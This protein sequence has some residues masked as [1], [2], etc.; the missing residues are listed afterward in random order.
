M[1]RASRVLEITPQLH[2]RFWSKVRR[3]DG[4]W[5][6]QSGR[7]AAGYG[8]IQ[9]KLVSGRFVSEFAHRV[10]WALTHGALPDKNVCHTCDTPAC[11]RP[12]HLWLGTDAENIADR[13]AKGRTARG[14]AVVPATRP[15][16]EGHYEARV[17][18]DD[19]R[20]IRRRVESGEQLQTLADAYGMTKQG[21]WRIVHRRSWKHVE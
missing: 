13:D 20:E 3:G 6:W 8:L 7:N 9:V 5:L 11:V 2:E 15:R 4:C 10:A 14:D 16:G 19:V 12:T 17:T 21:I 18:E 1:I